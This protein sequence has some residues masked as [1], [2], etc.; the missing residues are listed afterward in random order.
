MKRSIL[1]GLL[2]LLAVSA[3]SQDDMLAL[4]DKNTPSA[5]EFATATFKSTRIM[6]GHSVQLMAPGQLDL[7]ISHRFGRLNTGAYEFF[8]L[9]EANMRIGLEYGIT[10]WLMAGIGRGNYWKTY[11]GY[12][13]FAVLRQSAGDGGS[14]VSVSVF[15]SAAMRTIKLTD[16][17]EVN[18]FSAKMAYTG[19]V[20]IARKFS[21]ALSLQVM[22]SF[23][24]RNIVATGP[25]NLWALGAGGRMKLSK[26]VSLNAEYYYRMNPGNFLNAKTYDPLS[27]G[28]DIETGGHVF[29]LILTNSVAMIEKGFIGE[30]TGNWLKG[31]IHFGFSISRVFNL[32]K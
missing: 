30:T 32:K 2:I 3:R 14:P 5:K 24:S 6:N 25:D 23:I 17:S 10:K 28:V 29:Q 31:D 27:L 18:N 26:R 15:T 20:L 11:D 1:A 12:A 7:R 13:K 16:P 4:L 8:G 19:Q 21:P 22:P 9:D